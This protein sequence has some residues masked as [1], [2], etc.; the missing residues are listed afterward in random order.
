MNTN[1]EVVIGLET[2]TQL[3]TASKIFSGSATAFGAAPNTQANVVDLALPGT[4]PV[5]NA[6]AVERAIM[7]GLAVGGTVAPRS[8]FARK[9]YFYPDLP[10]G[11][12]ISQ[13][14]L[15]VVVGGSVKIHVDGVEKI[16]QLTRAH[17][18]EDAGK[19]LHEG[20]E[21]QGVSGIDLNRAG[22]PLLEIV[23]EP[24]MHSAAEAVA[25]AKALHGLVT[26][27]GIC[28]G[29]MQEGSFRC[30]ANV[31]VRK[32]GAPL[33]TRCEIKNVNSFRFL[34]RAIQYEIRRQIELIEDG[35]KVVQQTRLYDADRDETRAMRSKED[36]MDYRYFPD[37]DLLPLVIDEQTIAT[38]RAKMPTLPAVMQAHFVSDYALSEYDATTLT[39]SKPLTNY[40]LAITD[41]VSPAQAKQA[42][43]WVLG[44][45]S[46]LLNERE[47]SA[48]RSPVS[49]TQLALLITR[50][51]DGTISG[52][53]AKEL[54]RAIAD[55]EAGNA[56]NAADT[57]IEQKG[58]KQVSD[59]G[60]I[61]KIVD[62]VLSANA[63]SVEEFKSGKEKAFQA[64]VG[65]V[66]KASKGKANPAQVNEILKQKLA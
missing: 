51:Q 45:V 54:F 57:L 5:I 42:A 30:D 53:I 48:D 6:G 44:E 60:A 20:L 9:N 37:P 46:A 8:I 36:S 13:F 62:E 27:L 65:Q 19:S 52:K 10:K 29:N 28:D 40:F 25:Y 49:A 33:G 16:V 3:S 18:E 43:N 26:W 1:W 58:L 22:T 11:Y 14:E 56:E 50:V 41:I 66:M 12:Q 35:G 7:F 39:A 24:V 59:A 21:T 17:L 38:V 34:E 15:P 55:G 23:T 63:K 32:P 61:E 47:V 31:S 64:L 2:H 4:L